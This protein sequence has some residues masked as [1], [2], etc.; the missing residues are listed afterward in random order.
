MGGFWPNFLVGGAGA[1]PAVLAC[2]CQPVKR[3]VACEARE[4]ARCRFCWDS[5]TGSSVTFP[6]V[7]HGDGIKALQRNFCF[8]S[9]PLDCTSA[10][11]ASTTRPQ[12][13]ISRPFA[14][15]LQHSRHSPAFGVRDGLRF[16]SLGLLASSVRLHSYDISCQSQF[17]KST[18]QSSFPQD[19]LITQHSF[20]APRWPPESHIHQNPPPIF[21][22]PYQTDIDRRQCKTNR[23]NESART[24]LRSYWNRF[25][26]FLPSRS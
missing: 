1:V 7:L 25:V 5:G 9:P 21:S 22:T 24:R 11:V 18:K 10:R 17:L 16:L 12:F 3:R 26:A 8:N 14:P 13:F 4:A 19:Q 20:D 6:Q 23:P 15:C 2:S